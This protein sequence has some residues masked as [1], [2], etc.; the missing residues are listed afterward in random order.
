MD[1]CVE[2]VG[3]FLAAM[4]EQGV[5]QGRK[6]VFVIFLGDYVCASREDKKII[7]KM[8]TGGGIHGII[9]VRVDS[10]RHFL[11]FVSCAHSSAG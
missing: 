3:N 9:L 8:V 4:W 2:S 6:P 10:M 7:H 11:C 5:Q 1:K